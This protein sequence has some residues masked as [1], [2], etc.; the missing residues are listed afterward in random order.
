MEEWRRFFTDDFLARTNEGSVLLLAAV[1]FGVWM[2]GVW[3]DDVQHRGLVHDLGAVVA[4]GGAIMTF[5]CAWL[6]FQARRV[7]RQR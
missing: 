6:A 3:M 4:V 1:F 7:H 5:F 2:L